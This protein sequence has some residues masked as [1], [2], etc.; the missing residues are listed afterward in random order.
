MFMKMVP[1]VKEKEV[2]FIPGMKYFLFYLCIILYRV[3]INIFVIA[4]QKQATPQTSSN[5]HL[6]TNSIL[7]KC[8]VQKLTQVQ[9]CLVNTFKDQQEVILSCL[10][11]T[12]SDNYF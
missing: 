5:K 10:S 11:E 3:L 12:C 4:L 8:I 2:L 1:L 6:Q 9:T 7:L